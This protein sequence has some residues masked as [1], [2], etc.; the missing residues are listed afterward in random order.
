[1][2]QIILLDGGMGQE[3]V[4][5][6]G[7][8]PTPLWSTQ[9][10]VDHPGMV[11]AV[12][13]DYR[14][15]GATVHSA[16][17]Y[18]LHRDRLAGTALDGQLETL[19]TAAVQEA[20]GTGRVAGTIGPLVAS[21]RPDVHP[22]HGIAVPLYAEVAGLLAPQVD[23]I[24]CET[25]ASLAHARAVLEGALPTGKPVWLSV[26]LDDED[27]SRLRSGEAVGDV[28]ALA[29]DAGALLAN[30]SAPEA[31]AAAMD[32]FAQGD[33]PFGAYANGFTQ[34][35]KDFLQDKPTVDALH[36]RRDL[37][38]DAYAGFAMGWIAQ[39]ATIVGGC[40]EVGPVHI[41]RLAQA[42][43]DAGHEVI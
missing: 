2:T 8:P 1:M 37:G 35:T 7:Q 16:N 41:A 38:P 4:R 19:I 28:L 39:G 24:I 30:C 20:Q 23:L 33:L 32:I 3:L 15:A 26:T 22:A 17:T 42:I 29:K 40:C 14:A 27:G 6:S 13:A 21:Y 31:M 25:V 12:H 36:S 43:R 9:V 18:A 10:M 5:R 11:A 34:I